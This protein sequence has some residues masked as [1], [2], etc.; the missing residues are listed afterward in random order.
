MPSR[1]PAVTRSN[2]VAIPWSQSRLIV[3]PRSSFE[4]QPGQAN[5]ETSV[6]PHDKEEHKK[7]NA[8][9]ATATAAA[10]ERLPARLRERPY[11]LVR[12]VDI[13]NWASDNPYDRAHDAIRARR[14]ANTAGWLLEH[15]RYKEWRNG[16]A[17]Q[18][19]QLCGSGSFFAPVTLFDVI[20]IHTSAS[21]S[22][23]LL[24]VFPTFPLY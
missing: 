22:G 4:R 6:V 19:L 15:L 16:S 11:P 2:L 9:A 8:V 21:L 14:V 17:S 20:R 24:P 1:P 3:G 12:S 10:R 18:V 5:E 13:L 7:N 23:F